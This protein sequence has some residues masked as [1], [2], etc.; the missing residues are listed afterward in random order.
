MVLVPVGNARQWHIIAQLLEIDFH[1]GSA[2]SDTFGS[3]ADTQHTDALARD[4][5]ALAEGLQGITAAIV[6]GYHAK[7]GRA[8]VHGV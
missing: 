1:A 8:A 7:A 5:R 6:F 3:I 2:E 4:E